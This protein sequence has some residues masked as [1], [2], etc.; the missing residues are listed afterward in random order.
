MQV[1]DPCDLPTD[2][3]VLVV[4]GAGLLPDNVVGTVPIVN[5]H[6]RLI[7]AMRGLD[8]FK[9]AIL[10]QMPLGNTLHL[11][12]ADVDA[13]QYLTSVRT[14][15]FLSDTLKALAQRHYNLEIQLL[16]TFPIYYLEPRKPDEDL[17]VRPPH[18]RMPREREREML[19]AFKIYK[20]KFATGC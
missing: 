7:P 9:W 2:C 4:G 20:D 3:D 18:K 15:V 8:S 10:E 17:P 19:S 11:V 5:A 16:A 6:P 13:G 12:D 14:P 1:A